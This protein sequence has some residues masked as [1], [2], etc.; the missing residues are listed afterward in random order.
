[1]VRSKA[2]DFPGAPLK[3]PCR[4]ALR[5]TFL[6]AGTRLGPYEILTPVGRGGMGEVFRAR[7][8]RLGREVAIKVLPPKF[9]ADS[10]RL[11]RFRHEALAVAGLNH[12]NIV[13]LYD[14]GS[15]ED[16]PFVVTELL[17]GKTLKERLA[18]GPL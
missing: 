4:A 9:T 17:Q 16:A 3:R 18:G 7:D 10:D 2:R 6:A 5:L 13:A 1:M 15:H 11:L 12:P 14:V 8:T